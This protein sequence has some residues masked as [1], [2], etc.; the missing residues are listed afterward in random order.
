MT[1][2]TEV[3]RQLER[4][5]AGERV[6]D[7]ARRQDLADMKR[8]LDTAKTAL[9]RFEGEFNETKE[10]LDGMASADFGG[11]ELALQVC[12]RAFTLVPF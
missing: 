7:Y 3:L 10:T 9:R 1:Q 12:F 5:L 11:D 6:C 8:G 2:K 4:D